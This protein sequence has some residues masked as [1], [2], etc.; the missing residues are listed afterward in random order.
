MFLYKCH[1]GSLGKMRNFWTM[2]KD[3]YNVNIGRKRIDP[4]PQN[5]KGQESCQH[6]IWRAKRLPLHI[7]R[8]SPWRTTHWLQRK[9]FTHC[10]RSRMDRSL[11][12]LRDEESDDYLKRRKC[13]MAIL[14]GMESAIC[15]IA[16]DFKG[17][18]LFPS[19]RALRCDGKAGPT[20]Q[21]SWSLSFSPVSRWDK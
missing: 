4:S 7:F 19:Y 15:R 2:Q 13:V 20:N 11:G 14:R 18:V 17:W 12:F 21:T 9:G 8:S 16:H 5:L 10:C 6:I 1:W 3:V